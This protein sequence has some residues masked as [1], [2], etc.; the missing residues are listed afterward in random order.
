MFRILDPVRTGQPLD[1]VEKLTGWKL[2][3]RLT[4]ELIF[5]NIQIQSSN[6]ADKQYV[7]FQTQQL[8]HTGYRLEKLQF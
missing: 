4:S 5:R 8:R 7:T 3:Q 1:P 6:D 2:F